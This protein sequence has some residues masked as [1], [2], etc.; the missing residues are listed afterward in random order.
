MLVT[1][2]TH[3]ALA[4]AASPGVIH[5]VEAYDEAVWQVQLPLEQLTDEK[6]F[7]T[8][9][10]LKVADA[11]L[12]AIAPAAGVET[13]IAFI[14]LDFE[15]MSQLR[16]WAPQRPLE[17]MEAS[18]P[19]LTSLDLT[20]SVQVA[21]EAVDSVNVKPIDVIDADS[22]AAAPALETT[23]TALASPDQAQPVSAASDVAK[24]DE[25]TP[26]DATSA[27]V[28]A[29]DPAFLPTAQVTR[30]APSN[31]QFIDI[32]EVTVTGTSNNTST[33]VAAQPVMTGIVEPVMKPKAITLAQL[34]PPAPA[35]V[36]PAPLPSAQVTRIETPAATPVPAPEPE[37]PAPKQVE[38]L[39]EA[40]L[41]AVNEN[42]DIQ[43]SKARQDDAYYGIMESRAGFL[44][45]LDL[46][47]SAGPEYMVPD[48][49]ASTTEA[50]RE[51]T[52]TMRQ[53]VWDFG[54][55]LYDLRRAKALYES[56]EWATREKIESITFEI[57]A[58]YIGILER[59][60][61]VDL[62][63]DN[64]AAHKKILRMVEVQRELGLVTGA[65]VSR[66]QARLSNVQAALLDRESERDQAK[67]NY[68]RLV[69]R[70][71]ATVVEPP[72]P[73]ASLPTDADAAVALIDERSPQMMQT[74]SDQRS[75]ASQRRSQIGNFYPKVELEVQGNWKEQNQGDTGRARDARA[76]VIMRYNLFNG[77]ADLATKRRIDA[78][79]RE[80]DFEVERVRRE[81]EQ[82]IRSDFRALEASR[83]KVSAVD[84]EVEAAQKVVD[85]YAE[86]F[87]TG[88]RTAFDLLD[89]QQSLVQARTNYINNRFQSVVSGYRVLQKLGL[90]FDH[91]SAAPANKI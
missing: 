84:S 34:T 40:V 66:V 3:T 52:V 45:K 82:D 88:K 31:D 43:I 85:L 50:R 22:A 89:G 1:S 37:K 61:I 30:L 12:A 57:S 46:A 58:A 62:A 7:T 83:Q 27:V 23:E 68:R 18:E 8:P 33:D 47:L 71:P 75:L 4:D 13:A 56:A 79:L 44:P 81:V 72:A 64:V 42:P 60:R 59:E 9:D 51:G 6:I 25:V 16:P 49:A 2:W 90:L 86:Q 91:V 67:E 28:E 19:A 76:M 35:P 24:S 69:K 36:E 10:S 74:L 17:L 54:L 65:D 53:T 39:A 41:L 73:E 77:L 29:T 70:L 38:R 80:V 87:K 32:S 11:Q 14:T 21:A 55:T 63:R 15:D 48:A 78:R 20:Q 26:T 5:L